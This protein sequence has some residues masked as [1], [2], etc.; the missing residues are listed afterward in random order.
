V[1]FA[2]LGLSFVPVNHCPGGPLFRRGSHFDN[3]VISAGGRSQNSSGREAALLPGVI[4]GEFSFAIIDMDG[5]SGVLGIRPHAKPVIVSL[6]E[7]VL[8][9]LLFPQAKIAAPLIVANNKPLFD[10]RIHRL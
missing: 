2:M 6:E 9:S 1:L 3:D 7:C 5:D 4:F 8:Y 10:V